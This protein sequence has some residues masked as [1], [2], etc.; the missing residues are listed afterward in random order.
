MVKFICKVDDTSH[1][2]R[3][4]VVFLEKVLY[5]RFFILQV[6]RPW[7]TLYHINLLSH[8]FNRC[9]YRCYAPPSQVGRRWGIIGDLDKGNPFHQVLVCSKNSPDKT[10]APPP[11]FLKGMLLGS[12]PLHNS[13]P[14]PGWCVTVIG[15]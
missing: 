14:P 1:P 9:S 5:P 13:H 8:V 10:N 2:V 3:G 12:T 7:V 11:S 4:I 6:T 15:A